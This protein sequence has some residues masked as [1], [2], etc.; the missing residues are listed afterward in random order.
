MSQMLQTATFSC[1]LLENQIYCSQYLPD[2]GVSART[3]LS[4]AERRRYRSC[5]TIISS[6]PSF[7]HVLPY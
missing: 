2:G 7:E 3:Q 1:Q 5:V 4:Q 6:E